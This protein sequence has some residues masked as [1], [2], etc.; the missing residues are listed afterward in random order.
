MAQRSFFL[1]GAQPMY[2]LEEL[3]FTLTGESLPD[4]LTLR[5]FRGDDILGW[6]VAWSGRMGYMYGSLWIICAVYW[7]LSRRHTWK[8]LRIWI[9]ALLLMPMALDGIHTC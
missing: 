2:S 5:A 1:F 7:V 3:P 9:A 4:M 6:K 8:P